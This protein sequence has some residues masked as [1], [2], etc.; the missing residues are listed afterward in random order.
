MRR[1]STAGFPCA[2]RPYTA[3][4]SRRRSAMVHDSSAGPLPARSAFVGRAGELATALQVVAAAVRGNPSVA[5]VTGEP[6]AGKSRLIEEACAAAVAVHGARV[7][8][9]Y[10]L[11]GG[12]MPPYFP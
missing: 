4:V 2:P 9:G 8:S 7:L 12:G 6:V 3:I 11:E 5:L 10:A 1:L